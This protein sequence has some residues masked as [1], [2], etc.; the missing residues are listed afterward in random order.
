VVATITT[1][2]NGIAKTGELYLG[3]YSVKEITAPEGMVL[4][5][6]V[7]EVELV[8]AGQEV[9]I[10]EASASVVNQR[11]KASL[12]LKKGVEVHDVFEIGTHGEISL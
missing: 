11:Q 9:E 4:S 12:N 10:T 8:Y 1:D 3:R 5:T 6:D 7:H 2:E